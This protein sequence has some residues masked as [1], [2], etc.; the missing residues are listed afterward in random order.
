MNVDDI[1]TILVVGAGSMGREI[2]LQC[3]RH[4]YDVIMYDVAAEALVEA[5]AWQHDKLMELAR[6]GQISLDEVE[7]TFNHIDATTDLARAARISDLVN[8]SIRE[9]LA[10]KV[11]LWTALARLCPPH[12]IFTTNSSFI[13]PSQQAQASGRPEKFAALHFHKNVSYSNVA[14]ILP[15]PGTSAETTELLTKFA[16]RIGQIPI[17]T[18]DEEQG[19]VFNALIHTLVFAALTLVDKQVAS[20]ENIDRVWMTV[21]KTSPGIFGLMDMIGLDVLRDSGQH[22]NNLKPDPQKERCIEY[23]TRLIDAGHK[24][25]KSGRGFYTYPNPAFERPDFLS[26]NVHG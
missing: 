18:R 17:V 3:A 26:T 5:N 6:D 10:D 20:P 14:D 25:V 2:A 8:E 23:L 22:I 24:G 1:R 4:G 16:R 21:M 11:A 9:N 12:T 15:H 7:H 13:A 19:Y